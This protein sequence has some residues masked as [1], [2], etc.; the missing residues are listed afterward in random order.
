MNASLTLE[1][2]IDEAQSWA[3]TA[4]IEAQHA[5]YA[6]IDYYKPKAMEALKYAAMAVGYAKRANKALE[7]SN[8][9]DARYYVIKA[10]H[11]TAKSRKISLAL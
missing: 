5:K 11:M 10:E 6:S 7:S 2:R 9:S 4:L 8:E 3:D 1:A